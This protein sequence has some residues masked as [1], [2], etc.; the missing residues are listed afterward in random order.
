MRQMDAPEFARR[1]A[2]GGKAEVDYQTE[3]VLE[4]SAITRGVRALHAAM[5]KCGVAPPEEDLLLVIM[6]ARRAILRISE[7]R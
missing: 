6:G 5:V 1:A 4:L 2:L 3:V 7:T